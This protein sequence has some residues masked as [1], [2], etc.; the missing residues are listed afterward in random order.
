MTATGAGTVEGVA[1]GDAAPEGGRVEARIGAPHLLQKRIPGL[2]VVPQELQNAISYLAVYP[3]K[4]S[5]WRSISH[6][7]RKRVG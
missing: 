3:T 4:F 2:M 5:N 7:E 1:V 6:M